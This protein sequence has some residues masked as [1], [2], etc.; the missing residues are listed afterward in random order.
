MQGKTVTLKG[1]RYALSY[2]ALVAYFYRKEF[3]ESV[4]EMFTPEVL[5]GQVNKLDPNGA[6]QLIYIMAKVA[7]SQKG[8]VPAE[9][10][11]YEA[12][13]IW[14]GEDSPPMGALYEE[15]VV[16]Y[17]YTLFQGADAE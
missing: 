7:L 10:S 16:P 9:F 17:L 1:Q 11:D 12:F 5:E 6:M 3:G 14:L 8:A 4:L 15:A 13:L 2:S